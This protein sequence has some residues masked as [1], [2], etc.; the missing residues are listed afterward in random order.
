MTRHHQAFDYLRT[1]S[2]NIDQSQG[3]Y[4][5]GFCVRVLQIHKICYKSRTKPIINMEFEYGISLSK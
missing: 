4:L 5:I 1:H 3:L 2:P